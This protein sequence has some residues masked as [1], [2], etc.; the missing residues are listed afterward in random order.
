MA[1]VTLM[2][3]MNLLAKRWKLS[4]EMG[5]IKGICNSCGRNISETL[6]C[7]TTDTSP[8]YGKPLL[9]CWCRRI[10]TVKKEANMPKVF[11]SETKGRGKRSNLFVLLERKKI[12]NTTDRHM[13]MV[14][15]FPKTLYH[16]L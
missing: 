15:Y 9:S 3:F 2:C 5:L 14:Y 11:W 8:R 6:Q 12:P 7:G 13:M 4:K 16:Y 10:S 1:F